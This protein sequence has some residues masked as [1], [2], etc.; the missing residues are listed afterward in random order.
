MDKGRFSGRLPV[1]A[2]SPPCPCPVPALSLPCPS[3]VP[4]LSLPCPSPVPALSLPC[5]FPVPFSV[6]AQCAGDAEADPD[7][8]PDGLGWGGSFRCPLS[9]TLGAVQQ[10]TPMASVTTC[11]GTIGILTGGGDVPG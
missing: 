10:E 2:L 3:P 11:K 6:P 7:P 8:D 5:P 1:P 9:L 4:A